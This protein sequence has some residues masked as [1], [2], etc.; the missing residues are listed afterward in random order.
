MQQ[1]L[2][3]LQ[4]CRLFVASKESSKDGSFFCLEKPV[5]IKASG[6]FAYSKKCLRNFSC[7]SP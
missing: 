6:V 1:Y 3:I 4:T 7:I 5:K 2:E